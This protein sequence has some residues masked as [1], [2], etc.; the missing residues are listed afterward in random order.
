MNMSSLIF[1]FVGLMIIVCGILA[2][3]LRWVLFSSTESSVRRLDDEI[4]RKREQQVELGRKLKQIDEE[5][6]Q[7]RTEAREL[8]QKMH[9]DA[10]Q[11]SK[12]KKEEIIRKA[13]EESEEIIDKAKQSTEKMR[14]ELEKEMDVR[15]ISFGMAIINKI[16]SQ[17]SKGVFDQALTTEFIENLKVTDTS[18]IGPDVNAVQLITVNPVSETVKSEI[19][20]ILKEKLGRELTMNAVTSADIGGGVI[21]KFGSLALDG[22]MKSLIRETGLAMQNQLEEQKV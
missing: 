17:K 5:L 15:A 14:K 18:H 20:K 12:E 22:S 9:N 19:S 2:F 3:V 10:E 7:K 16:L 21:L 8:A 13:R 11:G 4:E 1:S 6:E